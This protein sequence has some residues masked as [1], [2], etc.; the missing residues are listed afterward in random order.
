MLKVT[1]T[2]ELVVHV[3]PADLLAWSADG[4]H[5]LSLFTDNAIKTMEYT[6]PNA[7][8]V[9]SSITPSSPIRHAC[10]NPVDSQKFVLVG[11]EK[12]I[13]IWDVRQLR[14]TSKVPCSMGSNLDVVWSPDGKYIAISNEYEYIGLIDAS[15]N[16]LVK[17]IKHN[18]QVRSMAWAAQS[19]HLLLGTGSLNSE[20]GGYL[21]LYSCQGGQLEP[22][23]CINA[24]TSY[25]GALKV[26]PS[27]SIVAVASADYIVSLWDLEE[28]ICTTT[29]PKFDEEIRAISLSPD[30]AFIAVVSASSAAILVFRTSTGQQV[31]SFEC[32]NGVRCIAWNPVCNVIAVGSDDRPHEA[33]AAEAGDAP[34]FRERAVPAPPSITLVSLA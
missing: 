6:Q 11:E 28:L 8:K 4:K 32:K 25:C 5:L 2:I 24:H 23:E 14:V 31:C 30:G 29:L 22:V 33:P 10:F 20:G 27:F 1:G 18:N 9:I 12:Q 16:T 17:K 13:E 21:E 15:T 26:D 34:R 3:K 19:D 7:L